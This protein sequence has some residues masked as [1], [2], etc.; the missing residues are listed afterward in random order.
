MP[1]PV[2]ILLQ[3]LFYSAIAVVILYFS[4]SPEWQYHDPDKAMIKLSF[5]HAGKHIRECRKLTREELDELAANMRRAESC[6]R[7]RLPLL[8]E[9]VL[10]DELLFSGSLQPSGLSKDGESTVFV[11][12]PV[13]AGGHVL[14]AR[15]RDSDRSEGFDYEY[16]ED[17]FLNPRQNF[18]VDFNAETGGF[19][20]L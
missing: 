2:Q 17:I 12:F 15:L 11:H 9:L 18:V 8:V 20:F 5:S 1:R 7:E 14:V 6:P 19:I 13:E 10:D 4:T 16:H 3:L